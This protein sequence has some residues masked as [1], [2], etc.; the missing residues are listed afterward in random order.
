MQCLC[1]RCVA[2]E[3]SRRPCAACLPVPPLPGCAGKGQTCP[4]GCLQLLQRQPASGCPPPPPP[5]PSV[6]EGVLRMESCDI[7][8]SSG[9]G[10]GVEG[11][12]LTLEAS[13]VHD[14]E[15]HG[16]AVFGSLEGGLG[17]R[18]PAAACC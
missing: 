18:T 7:S 16:I 15:S 9:T 2:G 17:A 12:V 5:P 6:Q 14:C 8:S 3:T 10:V 13:S 4:V 1:S 11:G